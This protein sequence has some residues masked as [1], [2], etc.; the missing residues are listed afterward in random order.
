VAGGGL[1]VDGAVAPAAVEHRRER[2]A[3]RLRLPVGHQVGGHSEQ[4]F[5]YCDC[6]HVHCRGLAEQTLFESKFSVVHPRQNGFVF[7]DCCIRLLS[8][9]DAYIFLRRS[10]V[11]PGGSLIFFWS[12]DFHR[13]LD[14]GCSI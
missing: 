9:L 4:V 6:W 1:R 12:A 11:G 8:H 10:I 3:Q 5:V 2:V 13:Q 14:N 7:Q